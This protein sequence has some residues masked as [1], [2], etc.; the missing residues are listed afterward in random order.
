M[1]ITQLCMWLEGT[2]I[3]LWIRE[4]LWGFPI[5]VAIHILGLTMS[6]GTIVWFDLRLL[7]VS[8]TRCPVR[9][10]YR[11]LIPWAMAGFA[12]MFVSGVMLLI[13]YASNA[14]GNLYFRIKMAA[15]LL[16]LANAAIYHLVTE[17][18]IAGWD[19]ARRPPLPARMA[20]LASIIVW[21][22][23]IV[24]GRMM[25]YTMF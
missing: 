21:T 11:R 24:A 3:A 6:V 19:D 16:A 7:G 25:S 4:T 13:A 20:G 17:R 9:T 12:V 10:L 2:P 1:S 15:L 23:V 14:Y 22:I 8:M 18:R 5:V